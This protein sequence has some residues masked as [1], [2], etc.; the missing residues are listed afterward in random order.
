MAT[1]G[2]IANGDDPHTMEAMEGINCITF[3]IGEHN[4]IH[5]ANM[6][7]DWRH[8]DVIC[9]GAKYCHLELP[10]FGHHN[11]LNAL[12]AV[13]VSWIMGI[14]GTAVERGLAA[15]HGAGQPATDYH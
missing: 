2:V 11:A 8:F 13:G 4:R 14:D 12:A 5:A 9:D 10:V 6:C 15:F 7:T 3:G 1:T